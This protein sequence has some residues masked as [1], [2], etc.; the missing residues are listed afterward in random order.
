MHRVSEKVPGVFRSLSEMGW[1][2]I[3]KSYTFIQSAYLRFVPN[4]IWSTSTMAKLQSF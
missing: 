2:F 3:I 4:E 1:N